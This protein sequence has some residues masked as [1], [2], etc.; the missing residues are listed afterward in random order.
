M[1]SLTNRGLANVAAM[2]A[3]D[4]IAEDQDLIKRLSEYAARREAPFD[5]GDLNAMV[6]TL[7]S[8]TLLEE[9]RR[10][11]SEPE[12]GYQH[13]LRAGAVI[14]VPKLEGAAR[15]SAD[16]LSIA[17]FTT[18]F[19]HAAEGVFGQFLA[20]MGTAH[21]SA[22]DNGSVVKQSQVE[23]ADRMLTTMAHVADH[24]AE[25]RGE[26]HVPHDEKGQAEQV[27]WAGDDGIR[28]V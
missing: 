7:L 9:G 23:R 14:P 1:S 5:T 26:V 13:E 19:V 4:M 18:E 24:I 12:D 6:L 20:W 25:A 11:V 2:L 22:T 17:S 8:A 21:P 3:I 28:H 27:S 16:A 10:I 15:E